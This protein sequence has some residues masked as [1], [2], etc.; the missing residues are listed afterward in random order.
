MEEQRTAKRRAKRQKKK[1][2]SITRYAV[3]TAFIT[4]PMF[5]DYHAQRHLAGSA[6]DHV[7]PA[8][9]QQRKK[10]RTAPDGTPAG[11]GIAEPGS[12]S[13]SGGEAGQ[14]AALD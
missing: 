10:A 13:E 12:E 3:D 11:D 6:H 5:L 1:V 8:P 7:M 14:Q 9:A 2:R 4:S